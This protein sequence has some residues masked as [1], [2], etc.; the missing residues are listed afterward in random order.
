MNKSDQHDQ[1][2][3][4]DLFA[5]RVSVGP[6]ASANCNVPDSFLNPYAQASQARTSGKRP[7]SIDRGDLPS[8]KQVATTGASDKGNRI[9]ALGDNPA[10][11]LIAHLEAGEASA[12]T[13]SVRDDHTKAAA[14]PRMMSAAEVADYL[15]VSVSK[16]WRLQ[17]RESAFP[18]PVR[19]GGS[20]RWDRLAIDRYLDGLQTRGHSGR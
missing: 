11:T 3:G 19:I 13:A 1:G 14:I 20:T 15:R 6:D 16:V 9:E 12:G 5:D 17:K 7:L 2:K 4:A 8:S 18:A 10:E